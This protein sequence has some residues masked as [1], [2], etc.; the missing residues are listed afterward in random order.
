M[1]QGPQPQP[2]VLRQSGWQRTPNG[3]FCAGLRPVLCHRL[4]RGLQRLPH[5]RCLTWQGF[6]GL[7]LLHPQLAELG[8]GWADGPAVI[9]QGAADRDG[10]PRG[11]SIC[12]EPLGPPA[13]QSS[14]LGSGGKS[15]A[16][17]GAGQ[18]G[19]PPPRACSHLEGYPLRPAPL[20][21]SPCSLAPRHEVPI[22]R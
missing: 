7:P 5:S 1:E 4:G 3:Q 20:G 2:L 22:L 19:L 9:A 16:C 11:N 6:Q 10:H 17:A 14:R 15:C 12:P 8:G 13:R 18:H 21:P